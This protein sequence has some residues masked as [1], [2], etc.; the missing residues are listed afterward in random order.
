MAAR[1]MCPE[2]Q[3]RA[4]PSHP[5]RINASR[6]PTRAPRISVRDTRHRPAAKVPVPLNLFRSPLAGP[7]LPP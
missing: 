3:V 6:V 1:E 2:G 4:P 5:R 7:A